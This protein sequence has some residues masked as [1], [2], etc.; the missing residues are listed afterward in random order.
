M[1]ADEAGQGQD[2]RVVV[3]VQEDDGPLAQDQQGCVSKLP[4]FAGDEQQ[5][6]QGM[7]SSSG[8]WFTDHS[9]AG[10]GGHDVERLA[11]ELEEADEGE[12]GQKEVPGDRLILQV[13]ALP[14][15]H[16]FLPPDDEHDVRCTEGSHQ[17]HVGLDHLHVFTSLKHLIVLQVVQ[18]T[19]HQVLV[20][21]GHAADQAD[22]R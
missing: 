15:L 19:L 18:H 11:R 8:R 5:L 12:D 10:R 22:G 13:H 3:P 14:V 2:R 7:L 21:D 20:R 16:H 17:V 4:D 6:P 1:T 9:S